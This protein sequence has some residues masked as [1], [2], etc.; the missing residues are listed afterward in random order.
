MRIYRQYNGRRVAYTLSKEELRKAY[1]E[2]Q[3]IYDTDD[4]KNGLATDHE[5][6]SEKYGI[7]KRPVTKAEIE[8]MTQALRR[9]LDRNADS[10]WSTCVQDAIEEILKQRE[11]G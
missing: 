5:Y 4:I 2:Q 11:S 9:N 3:H 8:K 10:I 6:Y 7:S 1:S